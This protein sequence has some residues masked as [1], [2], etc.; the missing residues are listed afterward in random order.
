MGKVF[1]RWNNFIPPLN[2]NN[3]V[4]NTFT[5]K[6]N[7]FTLVFIISLSK[8]FQP[9]VIFSINVKYMIS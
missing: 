3:K 7:T 9:T 8:L 2:N 5:R 4:Q 6:K 1:S